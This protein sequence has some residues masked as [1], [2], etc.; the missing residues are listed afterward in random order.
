M[1]RQNDN[2]AGE[3]FGMQDGGYL[4]LRRATEAV[5]SIALAPHWEGAGQDFSPIEPKEIKPQR[6]R[7]EERGQ[8]GSASWIKFARVDQRCPG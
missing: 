3:G 7:K 8:A 6:A 1:P 4:S 5:N 2:T